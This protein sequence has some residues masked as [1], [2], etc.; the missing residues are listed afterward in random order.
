M[1]CLRAISR[2]DCTNG[3]RKQNSRSDHGHEDSTINT[4]VELL[5]LL[6]QYAIFLQFFHP[7]FHQTTSQ[8]QPALP[9]RSMT[10]LSRKSTPWARSCE[11]RLSSMQSTPHDSNSFKEISF[12]LTPHLLSNSVTNALQRKYH[13]TR[14]RFSCLKTLSL[15]LSEVPLCVWEGNR[16]S[17]TVLTT[18]HAFVT[19][20]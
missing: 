4:V 5:L 11:A 3:I 14:W 13:S 2:K 7:C 6:K 19:V 8:C 17:G 9:A 16:W 12:S 18:H 20:A 1:Q 10:Y 15:F